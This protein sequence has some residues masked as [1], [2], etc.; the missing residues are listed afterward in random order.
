MKFIN[1]KINIT[2]I[3]IIILILKGEVKKEFI[4]LL[5]YKTLQVNDE[6]KE[7]GEVNESEEN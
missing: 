3:I 7:E 6:S 5:K 1:L 4:K 2:Y